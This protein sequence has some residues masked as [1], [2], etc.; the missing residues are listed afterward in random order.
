M[1]IIYGGAD[2]DY[3]IMCLIMPIGTDGK[4]K[5]SVFFVHFR[6]I[7]KIHFISKHFLFLFFINLINIFGVSKKISV[8]K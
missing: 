1:I 4:K 5:E 3:R 8:V 7:S 6:H 2:G